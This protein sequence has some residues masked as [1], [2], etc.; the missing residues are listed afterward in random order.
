MT[1]IQKIWMWIFSAMFLIPEILW[2]NLIK[3]FKIS[4][5]PVYKNI[6][7]FINNP[8]VAFL[9][10]IV[11]IAGITG[12]IYLLNKKNIISN[13]TFKNIYNIV[14]IFVL[15]ALLASLFLSLVVSRISFP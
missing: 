13:S 4:F 8:P 10:I 12:I 5:L 1:K 3:V 9:V 11:E 14:L 15:L 7:F 6:Q 2:G